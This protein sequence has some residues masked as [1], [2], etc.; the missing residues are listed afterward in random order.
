MEYWDADAQFLDFVYCQAETTNTD[1]RGSLEAFFEHYRNDKGREGR[2]LTAADVAQPMWDAQFSSPSEMRRDNSGSIK[3][4]EARALEAADGLGNI[5]ALIRL[6][7]KAQT[8]GD[9]K[10]LSE[11]ANIQW[12]RWF[13][14]SDSIA[15]QVEELAKHAIEDG[16]KLFHLTQAAQMEFSE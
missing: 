8:S 2:Y 15:E 3:L 1:Y 16:E 5:N 14:E 4:I 7:S 11:F 12:R 9:L 13:R 10:R 6:L